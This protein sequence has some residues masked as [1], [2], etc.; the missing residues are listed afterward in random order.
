MDLYQNQWVPCLVTTLL[1]ENYMY[2]VT[3]KTN[4]ISRKNIWKI[5]FKTL[6]AMDL[7]NCCCFGKDGSA[8]SKNIFKLNYIMRYG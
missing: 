4:Y 8:L 5:D 6:N 2:H 1:N 7:G 3:C